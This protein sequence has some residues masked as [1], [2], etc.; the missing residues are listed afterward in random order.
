M[1]ATGMENL[2]KKLVNAKEKVEFEKPK[3]NLDTL[4][5]Y[6]NLLVEEQVQP[7]PRQP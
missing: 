7:Q 5:K 2:G 6:G 3:M 1:T 4:L